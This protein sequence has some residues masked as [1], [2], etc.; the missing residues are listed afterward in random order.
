MFAFWLGSRVGAEQEQTYLPCECR[1][2]ALRW[3]NWVTGGG[4]G[5][6]PTN[7]LHHFTALGLESVVFLA[8]AILVR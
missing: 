8:S 3:R 1:F 4:A 7:E 6:Q 5:I 2:F